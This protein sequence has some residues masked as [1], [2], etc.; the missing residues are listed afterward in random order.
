MLKIA[1]KTLGKSHPHVATSLNNLVEQ[2][3][4]QGRYAE[5][6]HLHKRALTIRG[7]AL[8]LEHPLV[9]TVCENTAELYKKIGKEDEAKRLEE[10]A[11]RIRLN[12]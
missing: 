1:E 7:K 11:R 3:R 9:A 4:A 8:G 6:E 12:Q 5:A 10:R 2:Y